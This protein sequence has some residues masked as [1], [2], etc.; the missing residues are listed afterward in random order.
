MRKI[1]EDG[2]TMAEIKAYY[3]RCIMEGGLAKTKKE[4]EN[5]L[6][7]ALTKNVVVNETMDMCKY[8]ATG[9]IPG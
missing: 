5:L 7:E 1:N 8:L 9:E 2:I 4:A 3:L 6:I